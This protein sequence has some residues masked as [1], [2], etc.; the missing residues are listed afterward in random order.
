[1]ALPPA[2]Q[3]FVGLG[4]VGDDDLRALLRQA[5]GRS[6]PDARRR[7]RNHGCFFL[8]FPAHPSK[9]PFSRGRLFA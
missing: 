4:A 6:L 9:S 2:L 5:H 7:A 8:V 1:V 3:R